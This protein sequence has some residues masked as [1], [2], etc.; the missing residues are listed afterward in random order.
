[1][2]PEVTRLL[3]LATIIIGLETGPFRKK[4]YE[5]K[6]KLFAAKLSVIK[7]LIILTVNYSFKLGITSRIVKCCIL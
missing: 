3:L 7:I 5:K 2:E 6:G 4:G 1:M